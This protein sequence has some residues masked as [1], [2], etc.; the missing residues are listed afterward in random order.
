MPPPGTGRGAPPR[1]VGQTHLNAPLA[2]PD[3]PCA[4]PAEPLRAGVSRPLAGPGGDGVLRR[5]D[6]FAVLAVLGELG[7]LAV[8]AMPTVLAVDASA[9]L[10]V[11]GELGELGGPAPDDSGS[12]RGALTCGLSCACNRAAAPV[13]GGVEAGVGAVRGAVRGAARPA[14]DSLPGPNTKTCPTEIRKSAP[15]LFHRA[16]SRKSRSWRHAMLYS[17]SSGRTT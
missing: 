3:A 13:G 6:G 11:P 8:P 15:I 7:V 14:A 9:L 2:T 16:K 17:V 1:S 10:G 5:T 4:S 12:G